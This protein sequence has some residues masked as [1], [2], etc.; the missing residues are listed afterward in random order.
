MSN[1]ITICTG[2]CNGTCGNPTEAEFDALLIEWIRAGY[3]EDNLLEGDEQGFTVTDKG[4]V[5]FTTYKK[6]KI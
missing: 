4:N 5:Y 1:K 2:E 6:S 3:L